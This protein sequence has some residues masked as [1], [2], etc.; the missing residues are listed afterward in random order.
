MPIV[1]KMANLV[2]KKPVC[3]FTGFFFTI[4]EVLGLLLRSNLVLY[5]LD[6]N[7]IS[8]DKVTIN[9]YLLVSFSP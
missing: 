2:F 6:N 7:N 9:R 3:Q 8:E 5:S 1:L 4:L